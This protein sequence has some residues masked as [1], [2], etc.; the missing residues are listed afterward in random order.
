MLE[1]VFI[2]NSAQLKLC[3]VQLHSNLLKFFRKYYYLISMRTKL[4]PAYLTLFFSLQFFGCN[5]LKKTPVIDKPEMI[6]IRGG[7]FTA[8]DVIDSSNTDALPLHKVALKDFYMGKTEVTYAQYDAFAK[9]TGRQF[10]EDD[11]YGRGNRAVVNVSW[12][13]A[14]AY[15]S[16][17]GWRLPSENEWEYAARSR[18]KVA[19]YAGTNIKDSLPKYAVTSLDDLPFTQPVQSKKPNEIGLYDMSGNAFEW[20]GQYYQFYEDPDRLHDL[21]N[22]SVRIIRGG[23]FSG[24]TSF[25]QTFWRVGVLAEV[26][27]YDIGFRCAI[28]QKELNKQRFLNGIFHRNPAKP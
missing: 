7:S 9:Q 10:P 22:S 8:G 14:S 19:K 24:S 1:V 26:A 17:W 23:S 25:T 13:D 28:G 4:I 18:G 16:Y 6:L 5:M 27:D 15:C 2:Y 11:L 21:E 3:C 20:I 12:H